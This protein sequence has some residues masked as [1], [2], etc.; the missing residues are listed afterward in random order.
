MAQ[1]ERRTKRR[2]AA[3]RVG[4]HGSHRLRQRRRR[5]AKRQQRSEDERRRAGDFLVSTKDL[6]PHEL[7]EHDEEPEHPELARRVFEKRGAGTDGHRGKHRQTEHRDY[8]QVQVEWTEPEQSRVERGHGVW[9][10]SSKGGRASADRGGR[11]LALVASLH[12][13]TS[14]RSQTPTM[15]VI[16]LTIDQLARCLER[17]PPGLRPGRRST[18]PPA[19]Q[20]S[21]R[22]GYTSSIVKRAV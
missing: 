2:F 21:G 9:K 3:N 10:A 22:S 1:V 6:D 5:R 20:P 19:G 4:C 15:E 13:E 8:D 17:M 14:S 7:T 16:V 11:P 12:P 18:W